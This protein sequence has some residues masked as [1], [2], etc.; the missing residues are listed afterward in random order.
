M[1]LPAQRG[2]GRKY[3]GWP[4]RDARTCERWSDTHDLVH[5]R[6]TIRKIEVTPEDDGGFA[7]VDI[8]TPWR[9]HADDLEDRWHGRVCEIYARC[10]EGWKMTAHTGVLTYD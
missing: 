9:R 8:D 10:S 4:V 2:D 6:R 3:V 7:V 5:N 1:A